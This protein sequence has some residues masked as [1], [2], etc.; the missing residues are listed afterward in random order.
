M[1]GFLEQLTALLGADAV[2]TGEAVRTRATSWIDP[3][4]LQ[5]LAVACP[6][7]TA[8]VAARPTPWA[9][10]LASKP[11]MHPTPAIRNAK[12]T[13]FIRPNMKFAAVIATIVLL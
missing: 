3:A 7:T 10:V 11:R 12:T 8:E 2:L 13:L 4:P 5:A 9:S 1:A 6:R